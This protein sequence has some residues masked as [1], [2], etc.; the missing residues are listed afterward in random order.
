MLST[1]TSV[2]EEYS[3]TAAFSSSICLLFCIRMQMT[4]NVGVFWEKKQQKKQK[5]SKHS[6]YIIMQESKDNQQQ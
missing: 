1:P 3:S 2:M 5:K 4:Q 6:F